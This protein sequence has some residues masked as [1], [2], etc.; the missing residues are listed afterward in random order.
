MRVRKRARSVRRRPGEELP[1]KDAQG[2]DMSAAE[3]VSAGKHLIGSPNWKKPLAREIAKDPRCTKELRS[4][5]TMMKRYADARLRIPE[6]VAAI[7]RD[8][9]EIGPAGLLV[10][11]TIKRMAPNVKAIVAHRLGQEAERKL[12]G[13][14]LLQEHSRARDGK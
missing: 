1:V 11:E 13:A 8:L 10:C 7:L 9:I 4:L 14:G 3:L 6:D 5:M 2:T 12:K